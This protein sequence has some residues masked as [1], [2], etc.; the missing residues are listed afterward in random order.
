MNPVHCAQHIKKEYTGLF[1]K[2]TPIDEEYIARITTDSVESVKDKLIQLSRM[3]I[4][5]YI[6]RLRTPLMI[7]NNERLVDSNLYI[8]AS[9]YNERKDLFK[10]RIESVV[11]F[12][13]DND[14]CR[15]KVLISY[16]GQPVV[17]QMCGVCDVCIK[18]KNANN[19]DKKR[20]IA[21]KVI[22][23]YFNINKKATLTE[24]E[25]LG[26]EEYELYI[27]IVREL[28][29]NGVLLLSGNLLEIK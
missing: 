11:D 24:I 12:V 10:K 19:P 16:F 5:K 9:R 4:V 20:E 22:L 17:N 3:K 14:T 28:V 1:T 21:H 2:I 18:N 23:D 15:S 29:D 7:L 27:I 8:S 26:G 13:N 6:P 25:I